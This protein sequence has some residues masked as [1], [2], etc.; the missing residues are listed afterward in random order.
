MNILMKE[1]FYYNSIYSPLFTYF[2]IMTDKYK[3]KINKIR[4]NC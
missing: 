1:M 4:T 2:N 3:Y